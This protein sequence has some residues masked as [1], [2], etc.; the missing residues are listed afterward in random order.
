M[1]FDYGW[2]CGVSF[3]KT[4]AMTMPAFSVNTFSTIAFEKMNRFGWFFSSTI[5]WITIYLY[6][7]NEFHTNDDMHGLDSMRWCD[8]GGN[9]IFVRNISV[10]TLLVSDSVPIFFFVIIIIILSCVWFCCLN[11]TNYTEHTRNTEQ[12]HA[13][14]KTLTFMTNTRSTAENTKKKEQNLL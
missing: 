9:T 1:N 3:G 11:K 14:Q 7:F 13:K 10:F 2:T 6:I 8:H 4:F 12:T 5:G